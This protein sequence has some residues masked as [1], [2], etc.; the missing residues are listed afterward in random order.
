MVCVTLQQFAETC[1]ASGENWQKIPR[2]WIAKI[3]TR[4]TSY[5]HSLIYLHTQ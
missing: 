2:L 3:N 1:N 4:H 5:T